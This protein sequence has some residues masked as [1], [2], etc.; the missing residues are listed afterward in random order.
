MNRSKFNIE[1]LPTGIDV[2]D[3]SFNGTKQIFNQLKKASCHL[4]L[5]ASHLKIVPSNCKLT[6]SHLKIAPN[7]LKIVASDL[8]LTP[9]Q[10]KIASGNLKLTASHLEE[11]S[12]DLIQIKWPLEI[13]IQTDEAIEDHKSRSKTY[14][15]RLLR[16]TRN[17]EYQGSWIFNPLSGL[18]P[19]N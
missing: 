1:R 2:V 11:A 15:N 9:G 3:R 7:N 13:Y 8:K 5:T 18:N 19:K 4:Q 14:W 10:V 17:D 6:A 16:Y 12:D